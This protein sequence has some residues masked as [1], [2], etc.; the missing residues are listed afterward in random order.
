MKDIT[1]TDVHLGRI[2]N[3]QKVSIHTS[4]ELLSLK[5]I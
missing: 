2:D 5:Q 1:L 4:D 3:A